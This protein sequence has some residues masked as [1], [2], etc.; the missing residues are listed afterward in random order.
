MAERPVIQSRYS[1]D[2]G[3]TSP[4][5]VKS[6]SLPKLTGE[7]AEH[8][9]ATSAWNAKHITTYKWEAIDMEIAMGQM[10]KGMND[11]IE[12]SFNKKHTRKDLGITEASV[13]QDIL[14][15]WDL[16]NA[17]IQEIS[18]PDLDASGKEALYIT[19]KVMPENVKF[20]SGGGKLKGVEKAKE[21][22]GMHQAS[23]KFEL[24][25]GPTTSKVIKVSGLKLTQEIIEQYVGEKRDMRVEAGAVKVDDIKIT[26]VIDEKDYPKWMKWGDEFI[27]RGK[28]GHDKQLT[29]ELEY[30]GPDNDDDVGEVK[31]EGVGVKSI[32]RTKL[33]SGEAKMAEL[34]IEL[35][36][37]E[38]KVKLK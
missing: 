15:E 19:C 2:I 26:I 38:V 30:L 28:S 29:A 36:N 21:S 14:A 23:F 24:D 27:V 34:E 1:I 25:G 3:G 4:A 16:E 22:K 9:L 5:Y 20:S 37:E 35:Y 10:G 18:F 12:G 13:D 17:L 11:W 7:L 8:K 33:T 6:L 31:F 32:S